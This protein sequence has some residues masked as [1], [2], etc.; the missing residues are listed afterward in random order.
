MCD[1]ISLAI[2]AV[3]GAVVSS[4]MKPSGGR[5]TVPTTDPAAEQAAA[6]AKAAQAANAKLAEDQKRRRMQGSLI[7]R[8]ASTGPTLGDP[9]QSNGMT[10]PLSGGRP[11][12][13]STAAMRTQSLLAR[14]ASV[15]G[16]STATRSLRTMAEL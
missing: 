13:R 8:G 12:T 6:E 10:S 3:G 15:S 14:G 5:S 4:A 1:P 9:E 16:G 2:G 7:A 11:A